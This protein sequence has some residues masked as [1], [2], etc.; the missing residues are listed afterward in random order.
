MASTGSFQR[1]FALLPTNIDSN[2][3]GSS[4]TIGDMEK[5]C[6]PGAS[7]PVISAVANHVWPLQASMTSNQPHTLPNFDATSN[8]ACWTG[9]QFSSDEHP[10]LN[11]SCVDESLLVHSNLSYYCSWIDH[12]ALHVDDTIIAMSNLNFSPTPVNSAFIDIAD[13]NNGHSSIQCYDCGGG[14]NHASPTNS[15]T[16]DTAYGQKNSI[17][18]TPNGVQA[19]ESPIAVSL[20]KSQSKQMHAKARRCLHA[21]CTWSLAFPHPPFALPSLFSVCPVPF[22]LAK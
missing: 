11:S 9:T 6:W 12:A 3:S 7:V 14:D 17:Q 15:L 1:P 10:N 13:N 16:S 4:A 19:A 22:S 5:Q 18:F 2:G 21:H 20:G 8:R